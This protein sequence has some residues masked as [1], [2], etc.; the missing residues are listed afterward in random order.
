M[1]ILNKIFFI[2]ILSFSIFGCLF[3]EE[4][5]TSPNNSKSA[6]KINAEL[7]GYKIKIFGETFTF[8]GDILSKNIEIKGNGEKYITASAAIY[9]LRNKI[10]YFFHNQRLNLTDMTVD[11][12]GADA[13]NSNAILIKLKLVPQKYYLWHPSLQNLEGEEITFKLTPNKTWAK[14]IVFDDIQEALKNIQYEDKDGGSIVEF[15]KINLKYRLEDYEGRLI[16]LTNV[17]TEVET[18]EMEK[19]LKYSLNKKPL[20]DTEKFT[21][22]PID[23]DLTY[24]GGDIKMFFKDIELLPKEGYGIDVSKLEGIHLSNLSL[25]LIILGNDMIGDTYS[26]VEESYRLKFNFYISPF[27]SK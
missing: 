14:P 12:N 10:R 7:N 4:D 15:D 27:K 23:E 11:N 25:P 6:D 13:D 3:F 8:S 20:V 1:K 9:E 19:A 17:G 21:L 5:I 24:W 2:I 16:W 22:E 18:N 26:I